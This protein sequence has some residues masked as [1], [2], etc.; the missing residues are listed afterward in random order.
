MNVTVIPLTSK[1]DVEA[2]LEP[3]SPIA[4][5]YID[6]LEV[7]LIHLSSVSYSWS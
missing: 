1:S 4:I 6:N 5:A 2:L 3:K 7:I